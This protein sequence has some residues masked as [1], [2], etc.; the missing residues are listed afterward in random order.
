MKG[1]TQLT[2]YSVLLN[3]IFPA[4]VKDKR[5]LPIDVRVYTHLW[6]NPLGSVRDH[7]AASGIPQSTFRRSL[8]R[9]ASFEWVYT[10]ETPGRF[11]H[12]ITICWMPPELEAVIAPELDLLQFSAAFR[13][14]WL[15]K[16][17]LDHIVPVRKFY[18][19]IR[20]RWL[21]SGR[22]SGR[23]ELDRL[24]PEAAVAVE[25]HGSQHFSVGNPFNRTQE[26][27]AAQM[28]RDQIKRELCKRN[29]IRLIEF[30]TEDL[31]YEAV[32]AKIKDALPILP[33][34]EGGDIYMTVVNMCFSYQNSSV[35]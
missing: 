20:P 24:Y 6:F 34:K 10:A 14:E 25:F 2:L 7:C 19:N 32:R 5:L 27:L 22:G 9:L 35:Q 28:E 17:I 31:T 8:R 12:E 11:G 18:D 26:E 1:G 16:C 15:L 33:I 3:H 4:L 23:F 13:G 29:N 21:V 30:T